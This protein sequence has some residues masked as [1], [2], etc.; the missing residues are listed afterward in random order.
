MGVGYKGDKSG[1]SSKLVEAIA[2]GRGGISRREGVVVSTSDQPPIRRSSWE[3]IQKRPLSNTEGFG[4]R[5]WLT[6]VSRRVVTEGGRE[7]T[8]GHPRRQRSE[9]EDA[10]GVR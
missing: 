5:N 8:L 2:D 9:S 6:A 4:F 3:R 1:S 10:E 7:I